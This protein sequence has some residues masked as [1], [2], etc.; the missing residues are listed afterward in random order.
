MTFIPAPKTST[1]TTT[2]TTT[3]TTTTDT[4]AEPTA[5]TTTEV[6]DD[7]CHEVDRNYPTGKITSM[8]TD[9]ADQCQQECHSV[10]ECQVWSWHT[11]QIG[12]LKEKCK[13]C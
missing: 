2:T 13:L 12:K 9:T 1:T 10:D 11:F 6:S 5:T 4:T 3:S 7:S 8:N